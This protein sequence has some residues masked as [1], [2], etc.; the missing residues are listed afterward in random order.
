MRL[1][2]REKLG[3]LLTLRQVKDKSSDERCWASDVVLG[4]V[5]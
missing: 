5:I 3:R 1:E 4:P 2:F